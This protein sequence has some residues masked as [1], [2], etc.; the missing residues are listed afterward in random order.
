MAGS[1]RLDEEE[2]LVPARETVE[3]FARGAWCSLSS[4]LT[5]GGEKRSA[6]RMTERDPHEPRRFTGGR[7]ERRKDKRRLK[8]GGILGRTDWLGGALV[9]WTGSPEAGS[10]RFSQEEASVPDFLPRVVAWHLKTATPG[11]YAV[12][13]GFRDGEEA[14]VTL[15]VLAATRI[16]R[17]LLA[18]ATRALG[19]GQRFPKAIGRRV[20]DAQRWRAR[21]GERAQAARRC[22]DAAEGMTPASAL[23]LEEEAVWLGL[24][25]PPS[26]GKPNQAFIDMV[27]RHPTQEHPGS[28]MAAAI[29]GMRRGATP[30]PTGLA[31]W[32]SLGTRLNTWT[33]PNV[34]S[35]GSLLG[36]DRALSLVSAAPWLNS[37]SHQA[38]VHECRLAGGL[39]EPEAVREL[40]ALLGDG[41]PPSPA[42]IAPRLRSFSLALRLRAMGV[43][44]R[45]RTLASWAE[46]IG[47]DE[48]FVQSTRKAPARRWCALLHE[49]LVT[50]GD[51]LRIEHEDLRDPLRIASLREW[52]RRAAPLGPRALGILL[53]FKPWRA[54]G[55]LHPYLSGSELLSQVVVERA[56]RWLGALRA[57]ALD[58]PGR[59]AARLESP[60]Q[61]GSALPYATLALSN[62]P[63]REAV[64]EVGARM[65]RAG[66]VRWAALVS[67]LDALSRGVDWR[68]L[69]KA[70]TRPA[71]EKWVGQVATLLARTHPD[72]SETIDSSAIDAA[73]FVVAWSEHGF[74]V[75]DRL[76]RLLA[77]REATQLRHLIQ[78]CDEDTRELALRLSDGDIPRLRNALVLGQRPRRYDWPLVPAWMLLER[79]RQL[80]TG[81]QGC[82]D[83]PELV[84]R[85]ARMLDRLALAIRLSPGTALTR[86]LAVLEEGVEEIAI[87][88]FLP[89]EA[90]LTLRRLA[91]LSGQ[92]GR[93]D[94]FPRSLKRILHWPEAMIEE[95]SVL[96]QRAAA[97]GLDEG[98]EARLETLERFH[99]N[100]TLVGEH[101]ARQLARAL[102]KH[103]AMATLA[104]LETVSRAEMDEHWKAVLA[105]PG[106]QVPDSA[107]WDNAIAMVRSIRH[108]R[109]ILRELLR[110]EILGD[111]SWI[112]GLPGN[113]AFTASLSERG[114]DA[115]AW[116]ATRSRRLP[117]SAGDLVAY[118]ATDPLEILQ[119]GNL[120]GTCLSAD[121]SNAHAAVAAAVEV[122][123]RVLYLR[124]GHGRVQG[125]RLLA[126]TPR[127]ELLGFRSYGSGEPPVEHAGPEEPKIRQDE[128]ALPDVRPWIK[129]AF[130]LLSLDLARATSAR[131]R[132]FVGQKDVRLYLTDEEER[133]LQM[134][135]RGY[136]DQLEPFDWW[137]ECLSLERNPAGERDETLVRQWLTAAPPESVLRHDTRS[138]ET[139][140]AFLWLGSRSPSLTRDRAR[141]LRLGNA[142]L[143][144]LA[145]HSPST[146]LR[147]EAREGMA[148]R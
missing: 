148:I 121:G 24:V 84:A 62:V 118:V 37:R 115:E 14:P 113:R 135:C 70:L 55:P 132:R 5:A 143:A 49:S 97:H 137:I 86:R 38:P 29:L 57:R 75:D 2:D 4:V 102:P 130:D 145:R 116:L 72:Q 95:R 3:E 80:R 107:D 112:R 127:G 36:V 108:N 21:A 93:G 12:N 26:R 71:A 101:V 123:K 122:N 20:G 13:V 91:H 46:V 141:A 39:L 87:P 50:F 103:L 9:F 15:R 16:D 42:G 90:A 98:Q 128:A 144:T 138:W 11:L 34:V 10:V 94:G 7:T 32:Y 54:E 69:S 119:M 76:L 31:P 23:A 146:R 51:R 63:A 126:L 79:Y 8:A 53:D 105:G 111:R 139:C 67:L 73:G 129:L 66:S 28:R 58:G 43:P 19:A 35:L 45:P 133:P 56:I 48:A 68:P 147:R 106:G 40:L 44:A 74:V 117:T 124:D 131:L 92:S 99:R 30:I 22:L 77:A 1:L 109:R 59:D 25:P 104:A 27:N 33:A 136:F 120:F 61:G 142:Q 134:F 110:H 64:L 47:W 140:R 78:C 85:A 17:A 88:T 82:F 52:A 96:R 18:D 125:R 81:I 41:D 6:W 89:S 114:L 65:V 100:P 60:P 83:W